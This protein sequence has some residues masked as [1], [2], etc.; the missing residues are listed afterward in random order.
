MIKKKLLVGILTASLCIGLAGIAFA[1]EGDYPPV[2][3]DQIT[4]TASSNVKGKA[5]ADCGRS[6]AQQDKAMQEC[7][8]KCS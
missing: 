8:T 7:L 5:P 6:T 1:G 2:G 3:G 4:S